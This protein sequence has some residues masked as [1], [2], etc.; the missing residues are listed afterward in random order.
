MP[1]NLKFTVQIM[2]KLTHQ[3]KI[4][5]EN[6]GTYKHDSYNVIIPYKISQ[7]I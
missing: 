1:L 5:K 4:K 2:P 7:E 3:L 6:Y